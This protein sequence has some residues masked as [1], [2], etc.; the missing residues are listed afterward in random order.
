MQ[1]ASHS[2]ILIKGEKVV[3]DDI[4]FDADVYIEDGIIK[5]IDKNIFIPGDVKL[6]DAKGKLVIPGGIDTHTHFQFPLMGTKS[7]DDFYYGS[8]AALAGGTTMIMDFVIDQECCLLNA[9]EKWRKWADEKVCCDYSLH[10]GIT[11]WNAEVESDM[12]I[13]AKEKGVN[14]FKVFMAYNDFQM[15]DRTLL[16]VFEHC[17]KL[18]ALAQVHAENG[19]IIAMNQR[20]L[21]KMGIAGPEGHLYSR[22]EDVEA[23]ATHRAII[24]AESVKCPL[25]VVHVMS[26]SAGEVIAKMRQK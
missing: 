3:N 12:E 25:Y 13:L 11:S 6:L 2:R 14:S 4:M 5:Q 19:D 22:P 21:L 20:K 24:L 23:E 26:K 7:I 17:A 18:G 1:E 9:Y 15:S 10:I 16:R 8:K